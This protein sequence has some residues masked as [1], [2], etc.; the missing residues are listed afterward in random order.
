MNHSPQITL[1]VAAHP[2]DI[3]FM[4][5]GTL[6]LLKDRGYEIHMW[7]LADGSCGTDEFDTNTI[8]AVRLEEAKASANAAGAVYHP[9]I[10]K[11]IEILY[12][13]TLIRKAAAVVR[14]IKPSIMLLPSPDDYMEDHQNTA[15]I[16]V[17][18]AF[19]RGMRNFVTD[20]EEKP[21]TE[22][23]AL[24]HALPYG[25]R[26]PLGAPVIPGL[27]VD[28]DSSIERKRIMLSR[29]ASQQQWL[30]HSQGI[31]TYIGQMDAMARTVGSMSGFCEFAEGWRRRIHW[32]LCPENYSPLEDCLD[33]R[34]RRNHVS[35][36]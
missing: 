25:L 11:D 30:D 32:G 2:D 19:V 27:F 26:D 4:M 14:T 12:S 1:A 34:C 23:V 9:P 16:A 7:N 33:D 28:I 5:A 13:D 6:L 3:E 35:P 29:H 22:S 31:G 18:A 36:A 21:Y 10:A 17:T 24:Y 8:A 15:R 20:P